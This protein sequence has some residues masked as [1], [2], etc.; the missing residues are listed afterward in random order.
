MHRPFLRERMDGELQLARDGH[1]R[2]PEDRQ[3]AL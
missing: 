2:D 3:G 1:L